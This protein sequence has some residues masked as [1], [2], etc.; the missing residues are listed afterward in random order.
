MKLNT[1]KNLD[2]IIVLQK[3][4]IIE[5]GTHNDLIGKQG[6]LYKELWQIQSASVLQDE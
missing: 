5:E 4:K 3:G 6:S 1:L 2:R